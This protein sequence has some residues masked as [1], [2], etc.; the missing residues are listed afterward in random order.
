MRVGIKSNYGKETKTQIFDF[1]S[2][3]HTISRD[4]NL[5]LF[6]YNLIFDIW[7]K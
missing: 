1:E 4:V 6:L 2:S 3:K 7:I 5:Q